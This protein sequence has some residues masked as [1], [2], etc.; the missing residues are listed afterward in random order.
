MDPK[1]SGLHE[2][3]QKMAW[4]ERRQVKASLGPED[5]PSMVW[6]A[7]PGGSFQLSGLVSSPERHSGSRSLPCTCT[8]MQATA[9]EVAACSDVRPS[10]AMAQR[11]WVL[12]PAGPL[13]A[14]PNRTR[15]VAASRIRLDQHGLNFC[16]GRLVQHPCVSVAR[17]SPVQHS[18]VCAVLKCCSTQLRCGSSAIGVPRLSRDT[19]RRN[20]GAIVRNQ[21]PTSKPRIPL[22]TARHC[23]V[24]LDPASGPNIGTWDLGT[25]ATLDL[26]RL[27]GPLYLV[28]HHISPGR[29]SR[30]SR[31][32]GL[33]CAWPEFC[34]HTSC[35]HTLLYRF[36]V[37]GVL[38]QHLRGIYP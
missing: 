11:D 18:T 8:S 32:S 21:R 37:L 36:S 30:L 31:S 27:C 17:A 23:S 19:T 12:G 6:L 22:G 25:S 10:T 38:H 26:T 7:L 15:A 2:S 24:A 9:G 29:T 20:S 35:Q 3:V 5:D 13:R 16:L 34:E 33:Y 28:T 14:R 1:R 4:L